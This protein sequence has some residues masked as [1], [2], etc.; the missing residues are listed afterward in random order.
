MVGLVRLGCRRSPAQYKAASALTGVL[1]R[2]LSVAN[3]PPCRTQCAPVGGRGGCSGSLGLQY[4]QSIPALP[5][6]RACKSFQGA[7]GWSSHTQPTASQGMHV[8]RQ[9]VSCPI[10]WLRG[11]YS[12]PSDSKC[13]ITNNANSHPS[14][15]SER[16]L[17]VALLVSVAI[18]LWQMTEINMRRI[19][20]TSTV[21]III[22][23]GSISG[24]YAAGRGSTSTS[25]STGLTTGSPTNTTG[26]ST[27]TNTGM[28][29]SAGSAAAGANSVS[30]PSGNQLMP[31]SP[32]TIGGRAVGGRR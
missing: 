3:H 21:A 14:D 20:Y 1:G 28:G 26:M 16:L 22:G 31:G 30:N 24:S 4:G 2:F 9:T 15:H 27:G 11:L 19:I 29:N 32:T 7:A 12:V 25:P 18:E 6:M 13:A 5:R 8:H 17:S 10:V 23:A